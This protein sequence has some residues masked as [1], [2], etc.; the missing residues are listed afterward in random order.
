LLLLI[1]E[2][3]TWSKTSKLFCSQKSL[4]YL[5]KFGFNTILILIIRWARPLACGWNANESA[6][7]FEKKSFKVIKPI[8]GFISFFYKSI[9]Y[10]RIKLIWWEVCRSIQAFS[11]RV[12]HDFCEFIVAMIETSLIQD[13][14]YKYDTCHTCDTYSFNV[15]SRYGPNRTE[16]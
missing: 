15:R 4:F 2:N 14:D 7:M 13:R 9:H 11:G 8:Y 3:A 12:L 1:A 5:A 6:H 10:V 16:Y